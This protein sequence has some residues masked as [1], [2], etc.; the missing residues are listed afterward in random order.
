[1]FTPPNHSNNVSRPTVDSSTAL[2]N[3]GPITAVSRPGES[4]N[5]IFFPCKSFTRTQEKF[6]MFTC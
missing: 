4:R 5:L 1:M 6:E 2:Q 3:S